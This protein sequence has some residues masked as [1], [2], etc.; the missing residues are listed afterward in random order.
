M[1]NMQNPQRQDQQIDAAL[2]RIS[3]SLDL[4]KE[5]ALGI[6][7]QLEDQNHQLDR[8]TDK[9]DECRQRVKLAETKIKKF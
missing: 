2:D 9:A 4:I 7:S 5:L 6:Q 8:I 1:Y 3:D